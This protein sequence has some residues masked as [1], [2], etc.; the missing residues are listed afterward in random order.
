LYEFAKNPDFLHA[1]A[2]DL[3]KQLLQKYEHLQKDREQIL[4]ELE[5][6]STKRQL[7]ITEARK[8]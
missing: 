1:Q 5:K 7:V 2:Q 4:E 8:K 6:E 3:V